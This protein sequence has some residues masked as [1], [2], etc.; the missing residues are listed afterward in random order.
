[1]PSYPIDFS[2]CLQKGAVGAVGAI[3]GTIAAHPFDLIKMRQQV[4]GNSIGQI[5]GS[6]GV[7]GPTAFW[8]GAGAG[9]AQKV[10]TRGPMFLASEASTQGVQ[11]AT[12]LSRE[13]ALFA[14]SA[15]SG[16]VV[17]LCAAPAEWA[18]VQRG[19]TNA[20]FRA[21]LGASGGIR[22]LHGAGLR[23]AVFD[24]TFFGT[25][26]ATRRAGAPASLSY[27]CAA[28][29]AV[30]LDFPLDVAVKRSMAAPPSSPVQPPLA[31]TW[32]L[33]CKHRAGV[34]VGLAAKAVEFSIS[35]AVTGH[36]STYVVGWLSPAL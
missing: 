9:I 36:C 10:V 26:H 31:A 29:L 20:N 2:E 33:L 19:V 8:R 32:S 17:G 13:Y 23:N 25:E 3:P 14:G 7:N 30:V 6:L 1:M 5:V 18:K 21:I 11:R 22:R 4:S 27:G 28:A 16:Y 35:Y 24:S 15:L 34:F 12:G